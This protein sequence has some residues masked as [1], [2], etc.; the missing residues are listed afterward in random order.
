MHGRRRESSI[1][2]VAIQ[3]A[4]EHAPLASRFTAQLAFNSTDPATHIGVLW[5]KNT[6]AAVYGN[7]GCPFVHRD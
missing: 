4:E 3:K 6:L 1:M 5:P 7:G 2:G